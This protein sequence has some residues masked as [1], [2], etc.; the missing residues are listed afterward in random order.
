VTALRDGDPYLPAGLPLPPVNR[1]NAGFWRAAAEGR[2]DV[3]RCSACGAHRHPPTEGCYRCRALEWEWDTLPGTGRV[4]TYTWVVQPLHPAVESVTPYNV[5]VV[6]VDGT[7]GEPVRL[8]ST[9]RHAG[10]A[11]LRSLR[12]RD[13]A[14]PVPTHR[15][16]IR[17]VF[18]AG[19]PRS[20]HFR[21]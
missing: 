6:E 5:A 2:L 12:R 16:T 1:T 8:V 10:H 19:P 7:E 21:P 9:R 15:L 17:R 3:Q 18:G 13:R 11:G 20:V 4:F 14:A